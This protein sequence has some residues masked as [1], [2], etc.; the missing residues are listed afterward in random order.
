V[1]FWYFHG[2]TLLAVDAMND[3][4][5]YMVGKRLIE[6]GVS[7]DPAAIADPGIDLKTLLR[8]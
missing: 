5:A 4:R 6:A 1:G 8:G 3:P 7:P 2:A